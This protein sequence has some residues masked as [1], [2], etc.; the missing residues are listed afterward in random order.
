EFLKPVITDYEEWEVIFGEPDSLIFTFPEIDYTG[1]KY[2]ANLYIKWGENFKTKGG[3][4]QKAGIP[5]PKI[6]SLKN[7]KFWYSFNPSSDLLSNIF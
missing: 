7:R 5:L 2:K 3:Q 4:K 6:E 1:A